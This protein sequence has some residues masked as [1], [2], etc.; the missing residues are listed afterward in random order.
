[1]SLP[2]EQPAALR[3]SSRGGRALTE[4]LTAPPS[5]APG[6]RNSRDTGGTTTP[7]TEGGGQTQQSRVTF[8]RSQSNIESIVQLSDLNHS[9]LSKLETSM[10]EMKGN[11]VEVDHL[12]YFSED[13]KKRIH[14]DLRS[15]GLES[16]ENWITADWTKTPM[17]IFSE[18]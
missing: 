14:F 9:A 17:E 6:T 7:V 13:V 18:R 10:M 3:R 4:D 11:S 15:R 5:P 2:S 8:V 12:Q 1:M 16:S